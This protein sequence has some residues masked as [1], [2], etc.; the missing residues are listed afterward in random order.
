MKKRKSQK[1]EDLKKDALTMDF[2][3]AKVKKALKKKK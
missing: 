1:S 2:Y 3:L